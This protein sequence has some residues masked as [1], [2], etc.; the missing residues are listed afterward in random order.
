MSELWDRVN[1]IGDSTRVV[2]GDPDNLVQADSIETYCQDG[3]TIEYIVIGTDD[4]LTRQ[5]DDW[6]TTEAPGDDYGT[7]L[8]VTDMRLLFLV[9][10]C[11]DPDVDGDYHRAVDLSTVESAAYESSLL[12]SELRIETDDGVQY[13]LTPTDD[14]GLND[15]VEFIRRASLRW[16]T[17]EETIDEIDQAT[18]EIEAALLS[19]DQRR[20][21]SARQSISQD[22]SQIEQ[23]SSLNRVEL[24]AADRAI[25]DAKSDIRRAQVRGC[26]RRCALL[27]E[28]GDEELE[29]AFGV[30]PVE[31]YSEACEAFAEAASSLVYGESLSDVAV[32]TAIPPA[33]L[34]VELVARLNDC[35]D[36]IEDLSDP[37]ERARV[38]E[39]LVDGF[40]RLDEATAQPEIGFEDD[41]VEFRLSWAVQQR[42]DCLL[43]AVTQLED[44]GD[45]LYDAGDGDDARDRYERAI[46]LAQQRRSMAESG[47]DAVDPVIDDD[48]IE[49]LQEKLER[50]EWEWVGDS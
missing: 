44:E 16:D 28:E 2:G 13:S 30:Q 29:S 40:E 42:A 9:G 14:G 10:D 6:E 37:F 32:D 33:D 41:D 50:T 49:Q 23:S 27:L 18:E 39:L 25:E 36:R 12:S 35:C 17:I 22:I 31:T 1:E 24:E 20:A 47:Y 5:N 46:D 19:G 26:L 43:D 34:G 4:G 11:R 48:R 45:Q 15:A 3:A 8:V 7:V 21:S 38:W